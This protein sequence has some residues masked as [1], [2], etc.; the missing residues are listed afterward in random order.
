VDDVQPADDAGAAA[1]AAPGLPGAVAV[2][3][4][5]RAPLSAEECLAAVAS[6]GVGGTALFVGTVR[7]HDGGRQVRELEYVAH[8][9]AGAELRRVAARVATAAGVRAVAVVHRVGLLAVGDAAVVVAAGAAHRDAAFAACRQLIDE[10]KAAVPIWKR[11][12]FEDGSADWVGD[13]RSGH[14]R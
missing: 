13:G 2:A 7:D 8:P 12:V 14:L 3:E 11:Q 5:R 1:R 4:I 10:V 9:G 6:A